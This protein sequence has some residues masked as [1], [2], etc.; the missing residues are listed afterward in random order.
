MELFKL[1]CVQ[2]GKHPNTRVKQDPKQLVVNQLF[3]IEIN[4][5]ILN[6]ILL[7]HPWS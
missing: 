2:H 1:K 6:Y 5:Q 4:S 3:E 7:T